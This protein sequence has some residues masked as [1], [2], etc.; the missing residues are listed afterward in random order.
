MPGVPDQIQ[1]FSIQIERKEFRRPSSPVRGRREK[2]Q[3]KESEMEETSAFEWGKKIEMKKRKEK[4]E[5][6]SG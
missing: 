3:K 4:E 2:E 5:T 6:W 1:M